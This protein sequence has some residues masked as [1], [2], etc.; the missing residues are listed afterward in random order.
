MIRLAPACSAAI[1]TTGSGV[2]GEEKNFIMSSFVIHGRMSVGESSPVNMMIASATA[3]IVIG[4][5]KIASFE[6]LRTCDFAR[7]TAGLNESSRR[8]DSTM[9]L[10]AA[11]GSVE[12]SETARMLLSTRVPAS[13]VA[14]SDTCPS[15]K[16]RPPML[17]SS[18]QWVGELMYRL[19]TRRPVGGW[20][21]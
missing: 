1:A 3:N 18:G 9:D 17:E 10:V 14:A 12:I 15:H 5:V 13:A 6:R 7:R 8:T 11:I 2:I 19:F 20:P 21:L 16:A 4:R